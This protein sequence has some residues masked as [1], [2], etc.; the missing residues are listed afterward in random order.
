MPKE[1]EVLAGPAPRRVLP[2]RRGSIYILVLGMSMIVSVVGFSVL[3]LARLDARALAMETRANEA[4]ILAQGGVE[5][6]MNYFS[7]IKWQLD[8]T[9]DVES[10]PIA[11]GGG[12]FTYKVVDELDGDLSNNTF[13]PARLYVYGRAGR[14]VK[15]LSVLIQPSTPLNVLRS[16]LHCGGALT[17]MASSVLSSV[18]GPVSTNGTLTNNGTI[19]GAAECLLSLGG[20]TVSGGVS[21]LAL[22]KNMPSS[23]VFAMYKSWSTTLNYANIDGGSGNLIAPLISAE[24]NPTGG[25]TNPKGIYYV[26]VPA[27]GMFSV[28]VSRI[29]GTL[30]IDCA[31][32]AWVR[33]D[34]AAI[35]WEP[36]SQSYPILI[37]RHATTS[38]VNDLLYPVNQTILESDVGANLNP[39]G[40]PYQDV[41]DNDM[42]DS[43]PSVLSGLIHVITPAL[44]GT[45]VIL[46]SNLTMYGTLL[47]DC[48]VQATG[49]NLVWDGGNY[50]T[51]PIG[52]TSGF[53]AQIVPGTWRW[54]AVP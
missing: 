13:E 12:S 48:A 5:Y 16:T 32:G 21:I 27:N 53:E 44:A 6:C 35:N 10:A 49:A 42:S 26:S 20:G 22:A 51:P 46:R 9:S 40:T 4:Q 14:A 17:T 30:L 23:A 11:L 24:V 34:Q 54:E 25:A 3:T 47:A 36:H 28:Q 38:T 43:Y 2:F 41:Q 19:V 37:I 18:S 31:S 45:K 7:L 29:K 8:L 33:M 39:V 15:C 50:D 1:S 52:Y